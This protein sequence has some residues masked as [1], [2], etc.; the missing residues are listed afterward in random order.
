MP[1]RRRGP[2]VTGGGAAT[3]QQYLRAGRIDDLRLAIVPIPLGS[4]ERLFDNLDGGPDGYDC[5]EFVCSPSVA[6]VRFSRAPRSAS[7]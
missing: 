6:H 7:A 2:S 1:R 5:T 4:G 3:I